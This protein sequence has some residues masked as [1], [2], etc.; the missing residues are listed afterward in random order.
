MQVDVDAAPSL[1]HALPRY[2]AWLRS[3]GLLEPV[4]AANPAA[5][6]KRHKGVAQDAA[7]PSVA[8]A[9]GAA[10]GAPGGEAEGAADA[11]PDAGVPRGRWAFCTWS[12]A[13]LG[14][15]LVHELAYATSTDDHRSQLNG[16]GS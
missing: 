5:A 12:D 6:G 7:A 1:E 9:V 2:L 11:G 4:A 8:A 13:D 3:H 14:S 16:Q 15:Q 10:D